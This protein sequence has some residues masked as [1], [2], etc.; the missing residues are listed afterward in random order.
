MSLRFGGR[1]HPGLH[2]A[3][4]RPAAL[5]LL[6]LWMLLPASDAA[7]LDPPWL[8]ELPTIPEVLEDMRGNDRLDTYARQMGAFNAL[9]EIM[10]RRAGLRIDNK[11]QTADEL[12]IYRE[13]GEA[14]IRV[15][16]EAREYLRSI[17]GPEDRSYMSWSSPYARNGQ[18]QNEILER[19]FSPQFI[20]DSRE[21]D[22][23]A[24]KARQGEYRPPQPTSDSDFSLFGRRW[25]TMTPAD[26]IG[27]S[28]F[29]VLMA[30]VLALVLWAERL[31][32]DLHPN[33]LH[34]LRAGLRRYRVDWVTGRLQGHELSRDLRSTRSWFENTP[35]AE[36]N[37][38]RVWEGSTKVTITERFSIVSG[39][40]RQNFTVISRGNHTGD[41]GYFHSAEGR[42]MSAAWVTKRSGQFVGHLV[43]CDWRTKLRMARPICET[44]VGNLLG[45]RWWTLLPSFAL[46]AT[47]GNFTD[48]FAGWFLGG[49]LVAFLWRVL[50]ARV[51]GKREDRFSIH[52]ISKILDHLEPQGTR[53][54]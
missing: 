46:G 33:D 51:R 37:R 28:V 14:N 23:A 52:E 7:A 11:Q 13:Y 48:I 34:R 36:Q 30:I 5:C 43:F 54:A 25:A 47:L 32:F 53:A 3:Q 31:P 8:E 35:Q 18:F 10:V 4:K 20:T 19:Y 15:S 24:R 16:I 22:S 42:A 50:F 21:A 27:G 9:Q 41:A 45:R 29:A 40:H 2:H 38:F 26:R 44:T 39:D 12:R 17:S 6:L 1:S 49:I